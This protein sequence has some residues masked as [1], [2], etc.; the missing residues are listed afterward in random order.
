MFHV[1]FPLVHRKPGGCFT[2]E[3]V[4]DS[5]EDLGCVMNDKKA[6]DDEK[7]A[8]KEL[9]GQ[10]EQLLI[11]SSVEPSDSES[12]GTPDTTKSSDVVA[13]KG[14]APAK[15]LVFPKAQEDL[16]MHLE[17]D[18][19]IDKRSLV[20]GDLLGRGSFGAVYSGTYC[21]VPV[22]IKEL[23]PGS[24][25]EIVRSFMLEGKTLRN[26]HH[27]FICEYIGHT[28]KP[29]RLITRLYPRNAATAV[30]ERDRHGRLVLT[31]EDRFRMAY[32]LAVALL[33]LHRNGI[34][35]RDIKLENILLDENNNVKLTDFGLSMYAPGLVYDTTTPPG[36]VLYMAPEMLTHH[37]FDTKCEV[38]TYGLMLYEIFTG[39]TVFANVKSAEH[40]K[41]LQKKEDSLPVTNADISQRFGDGL[42]PAE[43]W[44]FAKRCWRYYPDERPTM[45]DV[46]TNI[47]ALGVHA[48]IPKSRTAESFWLQCSSSVFRDS[49]LISE[50][51]PHT[52]KV[53]DISLQD[54]IEDVLPQS[55]D[56]V[57]IR[58]FWNLCCWFP[59]FF[60]SDD[61]QKQMAR[62]V[63]A[64]WFVPNE[65]EV[66]A[67]LDTSESDV[68]VI[69]PS[70][71][72]PYGAPFTVCAKTRGR[73]EYHYVVR[74][75]EDGRQSFT[76][77]TLL[78]GMTFQ[79]IIELA[80]HITN[81]LLS[82]APPCD[83]QALNRYSTAAEPLC[84][85]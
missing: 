31:L 29:F 5:I 84:L 4:E 1:P 80:E 26:L 74:H 21:G 25:P 15:P 63:H 47:V 71:T 2:S 52:K 76:C 6:T 66:R 18:K 77:D 51:L 78:H 53:H 39:R 22:A 8:C 40:L 44:E 67:R 49:L 46:V 14:E 32:Q 34:L 42:P 33:Y 65:A 64:P 50:I 85:H 23:H 45:E 73:P 11:S 36:S 69:R 70:T 37:A 28:E 68:F 12:T 81:D 7:D 19:G 9:I 60:A 30:R 16:V 59:N 48:A 54:L 83:P 38:Y 24:R 57:T 62:I 17:E 61:S 35:H 3:Q 55:H 75:I 10:L 43:F 20:C 79:S 13:E 56:L 27:P 82:V 72:D 58:D 41:E